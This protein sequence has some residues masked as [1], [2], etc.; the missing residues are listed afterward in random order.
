MRTVRVTSVSLPPD[1][2]EHLKRVAQC[3]RRSAS[4]VMRQALREYLGIDGESSRYRKAIDAFPGIFYE[5]DLAT[6]HVWR[7]DGLEK[8][9]GVEAKDAGPEADWWAERLHPDDR[10][11]RLAWSRKIAQDASIT[12]Y[13]SEYR[14]RHRD[15]H[16]ITAWDNA[17]LERNAEGKVV[18]WRGIIVDISE[19]RRVEDQYRALTDLAPQH[20][21]M[22]DANGHITFSNQPLLD[23]LGV[24]QIGTLGNNWLLTIH[25]DDRAKVKAC[26]DESVR[27]GKLFEMEQRVC[28][29]DGTYG[30]TLSRATP[31]RLRPD[32]PI[33]RWIGVAIDITEHKRTQEENERNVALLKAIY[34]TS[35][36]AIYAKD[37]QG[38]IIS[39]NP[40]TEKIVNLP[41]E[42]MR[43][44]TDEEFIGPEARQITANDQRTMESGQTFTF[45]ETIFANPP[46]TFQS[47]KTPLRNEA[48]EVI[49][50]FGISREI[51]EEKLAREKLRATQL[52]LQ[53]TVEE[54]T[55]SNAELARFAFVASHDLKEPLRTVANYSQLLRRKFHKELGPEADR[56]VDFITGS[57]TRMYELI[58]DLL[59][60][61]RLGAHPPEVRENDTEALVKIAID[62]LELAIREAHAEILVDTLPRVFADPSQLVQ[63][64]QNLISNA[65]KYRPPDRS[66][67]VHISAV[68][69]GTRWR[70]SVSD[71]GIGIEAEYFD[72]IFVL[73]QRLHRREEYSGTGIGLAVC[74]K[75]VETH[76]GEIW[77][78]SEPG[79]G[80]T[81]HFT[82]PKEEVSGAT[83][84]A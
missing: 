80:S 53:R 3:E 37:R 84:H 57:V 71:N 60:F 70:F 28:R 59:S 16:Y 12:H 20:I 5:W 34:A 61:S 21:W 52:E 10:E 46:R 48:G 83:T 51:T 25:P 15:G 72:Q 11:E 43:G 4:E 55:R 29:A 56:Y 27:T 35:S 64:F 22:S 66:A 38:R 68:D 18:A 62:N 2:D 24:E 19:R 9:L 49:G 77:L 39:G 54:L 69:L 81:F 76:G 42:R 41:F 14:V 23:C 45:E 13:N 17:T 47:T 31:I 58:H 36:D 78:Q 26:W 74:K 75:V 79:K 63:L 1:L 67:K 50:M 82:L 8:L 44:K 65:V 6:G 40:A 30:W 32:G 7:S 73:F 33:D